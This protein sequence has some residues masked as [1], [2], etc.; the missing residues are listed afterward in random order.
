MSKIVI[1]TDE[2]TYQMMFYEKIWGKDYVAEH[3]IIDHSTDGYTKDHGVLFEHKTN[4]Q[5][6]GESRALSQALLYLVQFN[7]NGRPV[8]A[9]IMLVD[10]E[11]SE[12]HV[13]NTEDYAEIVNDIPKYAGMKASKGILDFTLKTKPRVI[14]YDLSYGLGM[15]ELENELF[16]LPTYCKVDITEHNVY[17][18]A[19]YYYN[20]AKDEGN[21]QKP[22]KKAFF[23]ELKKPVKT[24]KPFINAWKGTEADFALIM[25]VL[26]DP[27]TQKKL[28]A[29]YTPE[30]YC[31][32]AHD[33]LRKAIE[34]VPEGYDYVIIDRCAGTGNLEAVLTDE[35]LSHCIVNTYELKE[36]YVL[37]DRIGR[38]VRYIFPELPPEDYKGD[39]SE[40]LNDEGFLKGSDALS[41]EFIDRLEDVIEKT[42]QAE[43]V[44]RIFYENP[45]Y[46]ETTNIEFQKQGISKQH[47]GWK[48]SYVVEKMKESVKGVASNDM[49]NV[50]I[51]SAFNMLM[52]NKED[53]YV[54]FSPI[55]YW[56]SQHLINRVLGAGYAVNR[57][58]F[59]ARTEACVTLS[60]WLNEKEERE[61]VELSF[62][63]YDLVN[64]ELQNEGILTTKQTNSLLSD[65]YYYI[66]Q[67]VDLIGEDNTG[68][69]CDLNGKETCKPKNKWRVSDSYLKDSIGYLIAQTN[70]FDNPRLA[71][72]LT[73]APVYNGNG[74]N[75]CKETYLWKLPLFIAGKYT[76]NI[77]NWKIMSFLMKSG[78]GADQ[79]LED[80]KKIKDN[81]LS[82]LDIYLHRCLIYTGLSHYNHQRSFNASTGKKYR[83]ELCF[84]NENT[85]ASK[86]LKAFIDKGYVLTEEEQSLFE[87]WN[88][89]VKRAKTH[90][91]KEEEQTGWN[92]DYN[93]GLFQI[94]DEINIKIDS[95]YVKNG[96][97]IMINLDGELNNYIK[98]FK[99]ALN[100][101]YKNNLT[102]ELFKYQFLK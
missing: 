98:D 63:A 23:E 69:A 77:N 93:Y 54:V 102:D 11:N 7:L 97:P 12:A 86:E 68:S 55:K 20:H 30:E 66:E 10:Q 13:Y 101:Y 39:Y 58:H 28:G 31:E 75:L 37:K 47:S 83:S 2:K 27:N 48:K 96:K 17:G 79:Y 24:L 59:H 52:K 80:C 5:A 6:Y 1:D 57:R 90:P 56:K 40:L 22:E 29:F 64:H 21:K 62:K 26:N 3:V 91:Y 33:L 36:W 99:T 82:E 44:V 71:S 85:I 72:G 35:E 25:D 100:D 41:K 45:P 94:D 89:I 76:D 81:P 67:D 18:W 19:N 43:K 42:K 9:R 46:A 70:G 65:N 92:D 74:F 51:W 53:S 61:D 84:S 73:T 38:K 16:K 50:F 8:P 87:R 88:R 34:R 60:L 14:K 32:L 78:D 4:L 95:G 49:A 15:V